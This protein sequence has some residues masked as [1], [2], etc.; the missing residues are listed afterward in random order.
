MFASAMNMVVAGVVLS[1]MAR[2]PPGSV[3]SSR[4][5]GSIVTTEWLFPL[6]TSDGATTITSPSAFSACASAASPGARTPS[7]LLIRMR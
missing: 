5:T 7:S 1:P 2:S 3:R 6:C 4:N